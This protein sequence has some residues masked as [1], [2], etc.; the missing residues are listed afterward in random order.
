M[1]PMPRALTLFLM[2]ALHGA[3]WAGPVPAAEADAAPT[4]AALPSLLPDAA[5]SAATGS[6][7]AVEI[8]KEADAG[9]ATAE[10]PRNP[11]RDGARAAPA[12]TAPT[13]SARNQARPDDDPWGLRDMGKTAVRWVKDAVPWLRSDEDERDAGRAV[14]LD[15]ADWAGG[16]GRGAK[17]GHAH[18]PA[19]AGAAG[20]ESTV[21][22]GDAARPKPAEHGENAV[23]MVL[24]VIRE[25]LE[26]PMTWLVAAL[27]VIGGIV[28]K[29][30]DRRPTK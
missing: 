8:I 24:D 1:N 29:K 11:A 28:V 19:G 10:A 12:P 14:S 30:I 22:Y 4:A 6:A 5:A 9:A 27:F 18:P 23:R 2:L 13:P 7:L 25:V 16:T 17:P 20:P 15:E 26:H 21:V 3:A